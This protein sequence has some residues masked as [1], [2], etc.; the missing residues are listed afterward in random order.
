M[1]RKDQNQPWNLNI[2]FYNNSRMVGSHDENRII[3]KGNRVDY[4]NWTTNGAKF[5]YKTHVN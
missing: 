1:M 2:K 5:K 3:S 4:R